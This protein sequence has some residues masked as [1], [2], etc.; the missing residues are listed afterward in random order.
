MSQELVWMV[1]NDM[2][3]KGAQ[4]H[5]TLRFPYLEQVLLFEKLLAR[6]IDFCRADMFNPANPDPHPYNSIANLESAKTRRFIKTHLTYSLLHP[7]L[8]ADKGNKVA[9][10]KVRKGPFLNLQF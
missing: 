4:E 10:C 8:L 6:L 5:I 7:D 2:D 3:Y 9:R 1:A